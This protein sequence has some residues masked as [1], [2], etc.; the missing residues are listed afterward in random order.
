FKWGEA[1]FQW[2]YK[3]L[4]KNKTIPTIKLIFLVASYQ[5]ALVR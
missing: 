1:Q 3:S 5:T 4:H 2:N